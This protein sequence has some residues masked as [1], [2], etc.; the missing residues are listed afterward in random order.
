MET[1]F[2][3]KKGA[4]TRYS[5]QLDLLS[6]LSQQS[7]ASRDVVGKIQGELRA[8]KVELE[9][10]KGDLLDPVVDWSTDLKVQ[11]RLIQRTVITL[12][13]GR[14]ESHKGRMDSNADI[15]SQIKAKFKALGW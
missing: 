13:R 8:L 3:P 4:V 1:W 14:A 12:R 11:I 5:K 2:R 9:N 15:G 10:L 7:M 6:G